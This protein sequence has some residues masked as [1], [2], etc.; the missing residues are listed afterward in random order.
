MQSDDAW[1]M[2]VTATQDVE[3]GYQL[4]LCY[5]AR[6]NDDF[7]LHY[8]KLVGGGWYPFYHTL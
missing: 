1:E 3:P 5:G 6:N 4:L 7:F 2:V 8:G